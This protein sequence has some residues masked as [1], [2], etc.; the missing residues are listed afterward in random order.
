MNPRKDR[1]WFT[2]IVAVAIVV[3]VVAAVYAQRTTPV[4]DP[5]GERIERGRYLVS[6]MLCNDCHTPMKEGPEGPVPDMSRMLSGHPE[7]LSMPAPPALGAGPWVWVGS[8]TNT[9]FAGP[10]GVTY[11]P[12]LTPETDTGL[13]AWTEEIFV[14]ALRTGKHWGQSRPIQ[15]PMPW[16]WIRHLTDDDI[17][18]VYAYLRSIPPIRN[19]VPD[20]QAPEEPELAGTE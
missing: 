3:W 9:A 13:G 19:R 15:P 4:P 11:S 12:N 1:I 14:N 10:W 7:G 20:Y 5:I 8:G 2:T 6:I 16:P 17:R 18:A